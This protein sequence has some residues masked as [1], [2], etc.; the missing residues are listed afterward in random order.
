MQIGSRSLDPD[1]NLRV[2]LHQRDAVLLERADIILGNPFPDVSA[3][4]TFNHRDILTDSAVFQGGFIPDT[5]LYLSYWYSSSAV[6]ILSRLP[7]T[8][9]DMQLP[10]RLAFYWMS[11]VFGTPFIHLPACKYL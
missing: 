11:A 3:T 2:Q 4:R 1:T 9:T 6:R 10:I 7:M 8:D 5:I